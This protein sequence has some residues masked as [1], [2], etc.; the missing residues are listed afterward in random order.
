MLKEQSNS[1]GI[2][3]AAMREEWNNKM[4]EKKVATWEK[5]KQQLDK[6]EATMG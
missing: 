4:R 6:N 5:Q 1:V 2:T 3:K